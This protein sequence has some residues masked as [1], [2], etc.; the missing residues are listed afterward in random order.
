MDELINKAQEFLLERYKKPLHTVAAALESANGK[1]YLGTNIDHFSGYVCAETSVL[2]CAMNAGETTFTRL[3][4]VRKEPEGAVAV[5]NPCGKCRQILHD[6]APGI[7]ISVVGENGVT[8]KPIEELL[9]YS[10]KRQQQKIQ[11]AMNDSG[12][13]EVIG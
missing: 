2:A 12:A 6:Y 13:G 11:E 7:I 8:E 5:A 9:P 10:F 3:S 4:A 1:V